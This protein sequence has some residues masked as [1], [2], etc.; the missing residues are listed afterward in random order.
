MQRG[1]ADFLGDVAEHLV[2]CVD[3]WP[4]AQFRVADLCVGKTALV[5]RPHEPKD[6]FQDRVRLL[7][8]V[9]VVVLVDVLRNGDAA[10]GDA[11][12]GG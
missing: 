6:F 1:V 5:Q 3:Q 9:S 4:L 7:R 11:E 12:I 10:F 8:G 2:Q